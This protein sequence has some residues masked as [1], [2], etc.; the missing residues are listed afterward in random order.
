[1]ARK[2][3]LF[4]IAL[5]P[6]MAAA[7]VMRNQEVCI[8]LSSAKIT[9]MGA[10]PN[11]GDSRDYSSSSEG[12]KEAGDNG[13]DKPPQSNKK[14]SVARAGGRRRRSVPISQQNFDIEKNN[15]SS[16]RGSSPFAVLRQW[17]LPLFI[18]AIILRT[19]FSGSANN[20]NV[21]YYSSSVYQSTIYRDGNIETTRREN[22]ESNIPG[23][24]GQSA[25]NMQQKFRDLHTFDRFEEELEDN[26]IDSMLFRKW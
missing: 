3:V 24:T 9:L 23:L 18:L 17:A 15:N 10:S 4:L 12:D 1:M 13:P 20:P 7:F 14:Y 26:I 22:F 21:V 11:N 8:P 19:M 25:E 16:E 2:A 6:S 5:L